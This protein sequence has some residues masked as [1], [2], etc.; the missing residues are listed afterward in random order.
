MIAHFIQQFYLSSSS[1]TDNAT[2]TVTNLRCTCPH[3]YITASLT[4]LHGCHSHLKFNIS[5]TDF[6]LPKSPNLLNIFFHISMTTLSNH[7][8]NMIHSL[9]CQKQGIYPWFLFFHYPYIQFCPF[10][11]SNAFLKSLYFCL[12]SFATNLVQATIISFVEFLLIL[13]HSP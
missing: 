2:S 12:V 10:Y 3:I 1:P 13:I 9:S 4:S 11:L 8:G 7:V 5:K 6:Y